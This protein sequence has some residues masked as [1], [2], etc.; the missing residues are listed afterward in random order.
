MPI[1]NRDWKYMKTTLDTILGIWMKSPALRLGQLIE[2]AVG[3]Y[4]HAPTFYVE[5]AALL[6]A[7]KRFNK[8]FSDGGGTADTPGSGPGAPKGA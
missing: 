1:P 3:R 7:L 4:Q 6:D 8:D 5:D 2:N